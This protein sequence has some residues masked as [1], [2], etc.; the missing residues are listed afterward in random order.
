VNGNAHAIVTFN[1]RDF[2]GISRDFGCAVIL[3]GAAL[4]HATVTDQACPN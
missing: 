4:Q 1:R 2:E 3:P